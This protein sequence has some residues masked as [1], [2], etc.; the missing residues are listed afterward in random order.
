MGEK[1]APGPPPRDTVN[2]FVRLRREELVYL[3]G[4]LETYDDLAVLKT[5]DTGA[6]VAVLMVPPRQE[7]TLREL[8]SSLAGELGLEH[9]E[10]DP[11]DRRRYEELIYGLE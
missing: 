4:V 10:P 11:P 8:L 5:L 2:L 7:Q 3:N 1:I 9:L 6:G